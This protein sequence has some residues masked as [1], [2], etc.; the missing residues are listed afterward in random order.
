MKKITSF[1]IDRTN[2]K[3]QNHIPTRIYAQYNE[4]RLS[5][6]SEK[7]KVRSSTRACIHGNITQTLVCIVGWARVLEVLLEMFGELAR[8]DV[9]S[10]S[11]DDFSLLVD[12]ELGEVPFDEAAKSA[13][14]LL[15]QVLPERVRVV[16]VHVDLLEQVKL[17]LRDTKN[18]RCNL[19]N[20]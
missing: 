7:R 3:Q 20:E 19:S 9:G 5:K 15:L 11:L 13:T 4:Q 8:V 14:L 16:A 18:A 12:D 17:H 10:M 1:T 6:F 2:W